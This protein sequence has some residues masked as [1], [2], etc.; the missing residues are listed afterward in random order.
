MPKK[1]LED[2]KP[3]ARRAP[4]SRAESSVRISHDLPRE[5]PFEPMDR[6]QSSRYGM[7]YVAVFF[8]IVCL[9]SLS[10]L[11]EKAAITVTPKSL[12]VAYDASDTFTAEK[13][14]TLDDTIIYT[15]MTLDGDQSIRLPSTISKT[16][17]HP[18]KGRVVL[19]NTYTNA[20]YKLVQNTRLATPDSRIYRIDSGVTI[21]GYTKSSGTI[22]PGSVEVD[23]TAATS[24]ESGNVENSDFTVPGLAGSPQATKIY[25]RSKTAIT[26]GVSGT[27]YSI[28]P[29]A[30]NAALGTLKEKLQTSLIAKAKAQLP[31]GYLLLDGS[32][33]F[34]ADD[35]VQAPY[36]KDQQVPLA[37]HGTL[38]AYLIKESTLVQAIAEKSISQ[39]NGEQVTVPNLASITLVPGGPITAGSDAGFPFTLSGSIK[40]VWTVNSDDV[41]KLFAGQKKS[42]L[43]TILSDVPAIDRAEVVLK[44]FWKQS[45]P[46]DPN[47]I[48]VT[49]IAP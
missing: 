3:I 19:Y 40:I 1:I 37:L 39:Y 38:T 13:D 29:D 9:F 45:F 25:G 28:P 26:G 14:S 47:R 2:I 34:T 48:T 32:T 24:G 30:A 35:T 10:F 27:I 17:T 11:F 7:W 23:V 16:E 21:P 44:P 41:K 49:Q 18:A 15:E 31:E 43:T 5:V 33:S 46:S 8:V 22:T 4:R 36:S 42:A 12:S 6:P 20:P